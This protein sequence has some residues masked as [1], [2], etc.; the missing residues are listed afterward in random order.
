MSAPILWIIIPL[1]LSAFMLFFLQYSRLVK[2]LGIVA[3]LI[4][5]LIAIIQPIGNVLNIGN[6]VLDI[7]PAFYIFGRSLLL[8]NTDRFALSLVYTTLLLFLL[9]MDRST[10]PAKFVPLSMA[11]SSLLIA[12]RTDFRESSASPLSMAVRASFTA[13]RASPR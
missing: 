3:S 13:V 10:V 7:S 8:E 1:A 4:L 12:A 6:M 9:L 5:A 2:I 11:V